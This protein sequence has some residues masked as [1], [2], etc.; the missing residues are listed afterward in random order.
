MRQTYAKR[1]YV[2]LH[3]DGSIHYPFSKFLTDKFNNPHTRE[4]VAQSLRVFYRFCS[5]HQIELLLRA[6][7]GRCLTY[8]EAK[9]L[10]ELCY[11]PLSE[12]E[13]MGD[14]KVIFLTSAKAGKAP[15]ELAGGLVDLY[16][17]I[18][19]CIPSLLAL[20]IAVTQVH[21]PKVPR[22]NRKALT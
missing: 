7:D 11:R 22:R 3:D 5:A 17:D 16:Y 9:R 15:Y 2:L 19:Y 18:W 12:V 1:N 6:M 4:L 8:D 14:K 20:R 10:A 21:N 13:A